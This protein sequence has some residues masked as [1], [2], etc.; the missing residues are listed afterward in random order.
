LA[1]VDHRLQHARQL[2]RGGG[3][4]ARRAELGLHPPEPIAQLAFN[5]VQRLR[6]QPQREKTDRS[7][8]QLWNFRLC[9]IG[10]FTYPPYSGRGQI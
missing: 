8:N 6:L 3:D 2:S 7:F 9:H 5:A 1:V 4:G 10:A